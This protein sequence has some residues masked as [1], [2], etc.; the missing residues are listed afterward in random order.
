MSH[1][2]FRS[3]ALFLTLALALVTLAL[4]RP[5]MARAGSLPQMQR[6]TPLADVL[7]PDGTLGLPKGK[8]GNLDPTGF[9]LVS[10][11]DEQPR[12]APQTLTNPG[13]EN[14]ASG[15]FGGG[16][17]GSVW[18]L[19]F[20]SSGNLYAGGDFSSAG[21]CNSGCNRI[22]KW[23]GSTWSALGTGMNQ[24]VNAIAF[25]G[26]GNL[27]AGG[28]FTTAGTCTTGC[29]RVA[30][31]NGSTWSALGS[32][33]NNGSV[34]AV[35]FDGASTLYVGG[36]FT[37][38][39]GCSG[40][41]E[42]LV[43]WNVGTS[44]WS[45]LG[46]YG[47]VSGP[48]YAL[49]YSG[50]ALYVGGDFGSAGNCS[51]SCHRIA[52]WNGTFWESLGGGVNNTVYAIAT[53]SSG[54]VYAGGNFDVAGLTCTYGMGCNR[55]AKWNP[56]TLTWSALGSGWNNTVETL[57]LDSSGILYAGGRFAP[58]CGG[59]FYIAQW[60][61]SSS[62]W[63]PMQGGTNSPV[64]ALALGGSNLYAGG[65]FSSAGNCGSGCPFIARW[66]S[67]S[68]TWN[69]LTGNGLGNF[70]GSSG[71]IGDLAVDS[72]DN[73]Y[74]S[75]S[76]LRAGS[77]LINCNY[78]AKW[79][80]MT[81]TWSSLSSNPPIN[82]YAFAFDSAGNLYVGGQFTSAGSCT[83]V[84]GCN[85]VAKWDPLTLT[86]SA[87]G[88]GMSNGS[89][90][91]LAFDSSGNLYAGGSFTSAGTCTTGCA[92]IAK[93]NPGSSTWTSL[94][95][96]FGSGSTVH[97]LAFDG[98]NTLYVGGFF[99]AAGNCTLNCTNIAKWNI[100]AS[101]WSALDTG[102]SGGSAYAFALDGNNLYAGGQFT[103]AGSC[104]SGCANL[105]KWNISTSTWSALGTGINGNV[106]ALALDSTSNLYAGGL[107]TSAGSCTTGCNRVA[108]WDGTTWSALGTG[109]NSNV[110]ALAFTSMGNL[111][112]G[113]SFSTSGGIPSIG[114]AQWTAAVG[115]AVNG[116]GSLTFYANNLPVTI[117]VTAQG[118]LARVNIQRVNTSYSG[119]PST[120][121]TGYYWSIEGL[122]SSG[123]TATGFSVNLTLPTPNFAPSASSKLCR[124]TGVNGNC[125]ITSFD[126]GSVTR[127]NV[128]G[129]SDWLAASD[130]APTA[131]TLVK[132][133]TKFAPK[134]NV[135]R[136]R[137]ET[138]SELNVVG[139]SVYRRTGNT[140]KWTRLNA[141]MIPA[142]NV[143]QIQG[144]KYSF[145][146]KK[147]KGGKIYRY[148]LEL[149]LS[150]G[151]SEWS[152]IINPFK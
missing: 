69:P 45:Q 53:D 28:D 81:S 78:L 104:S 32:G 85:R 86:W 84:N 4:S 110:S 27:Y 5:P 64:L 143:G 6:G 67:S 103:S 1:K 118:D 91:A 71:S 93:W 3:L 109:M 144:D 8:S 12:F 76:F 15:F 70:G 131:A 26:S 51:S 80:P 95:T 117:D 65:D 114:I 107:F 2:P 36:N 132:F 49:T 136:V 41:C 60:N 98:A 77:C 146:D 147:I 30:K 135:V 105:A 73:V 47:N 43:K 96:G 90:L 88:I 29:N 122:N 31:W 79:N 128:I 134:K 123:G 52:K 120:W 74:A 92:S 94:G 130:A 19:A 101:T 24:R 59:C 149:V 58:G 145:T 102:L 115:K 87:L 14:W 89:V 37:S 121:Q 124:M 66:N 7:N 127:N 61:V 82:V 10:G 100:A 112:V 83:S 133:N 46:S 140:K 142:K 139:F 106:F 129:F 75:G 34:Q 18:A 137:W 9:S 148:K 126:S 57:A 72:S 39:T 40:L 99:T 16:V 151:T 150:D 141:E 97:A 42:F 108:K 54:N 33:V 22:A 11:P 23:N 111:Y 116:T 17:A 55:I 125:K 56:S 48:V 25:D 63:S 152:K 62:T 35:A 21:N 44:T 38:A 138:G 20:D 50:T 119:V 113:G 68:S 13:N